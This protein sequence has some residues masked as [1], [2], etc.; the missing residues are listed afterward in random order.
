M[1]TMD[2]NTFV[3]QYGSISRR[4]LLR[5]GGSLALAAPAT[6]LLAACGGG[7][8]NKT[9]T[10]AGAS[11]SASESTAASTQPASSASP[12]ATSGS[13]SASPASG[14]P[15]GSG[16]SSGS[17][18]SPK[19]LGMVPEGVKPG[20]TLTVAIGTDISSFEPQQTTETSSTGVRVNLYDPLVW[21]E[22]QK[23]EIIPWLASK[24][25]ISDDG[26]TYTFTLIDKPVKFHDGTTLTTDAVKKTFDR[27]LTENKATAAGIDFV[28]ILQTVDV[29]D[30]KT[31]KFTLGAPFAP[32]M[33]RMGYNAAAIM[34][35]DAIDKYGKDYG[36]HA[37]GTGPYKFVEY[38]KGDHATFEKNPDYWNGDVYY[39]KMIYKIVPED[40]SRS[41]L[42]Q[43][44]EAQV[45]DRIPP[46]LAK[47][48]EGNQNAGIRID[49]TSRYVFM[50]LNTTRAPF[51]NVKARQAVNYGVDNKSLVDN[52]LKGY[53]EVPD[54][55]I[56]SVAQYY[57]KQEPYTYDVDKA[58]S[59]LQEAG[60]K[61][62]TPLTIWTPQGRYVGD[63]DIA[64]A[65]QG[66][67]KDLGFDPQVQVF[68]D[69][70]T[71]LN[72]LN[73]FDCDMAI[74][75]WVSPD[76]DVGLNNV[77][78]G[79][80]A[81]KFPNNGGYKNDKVDELLDKAVQSTSEDERA[82][83]Y[84]Q[85]QTLI[86]QDAPVVWLD[87]Q[88]NLTGVSKKIVNV[89]DDLQEVLVVRFSGS[90]S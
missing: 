25:D 6:A 51:N 23:W 66:M 63:K 35:P 85:A 8:D 55:P 15:T 44:G 45:A 79:K 83:L 31:V 3:R 87:W 60:V 4:T 24:W 53:G 1:L 59:L 62:G 42:V 17:T 37:I 78:S 65:V 14:T 18:A 22:N 84:G 69:F 7:S 86:W 61:S 88:Q 38:R 12:A 89:F 5:I 49:K 26:L 16:T 20:G 57:K 21:V 68:G 50:L 70:P 39:D 58:K 32:F 2:P 67:M 34:S 82:D 41:T 71:Y 43:T 28:G 76:P 19:D 54:A 80:L 56:P 33:T 75:G 64:T 40:A 47:A 72:Q 30:D 29:V 36:S 52:I 90:T 73:K 77:Y 9:A 11:T 81:G 10:S 74:L 27:L 13:S 46:V 48:L